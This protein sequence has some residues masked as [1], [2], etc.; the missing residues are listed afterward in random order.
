MYTMK[1]DL[2]GKEF[3]LLLLLISFVIGFP[4][5]KSLNWL[6]PSVFAVILGM[7]VSAVGGKSVSFATEMFLYLGLPPILFHSAL[8]FKLGSLKKTWLSS[9]LLSWFVTL[10]SILLIAWGILVWT[11]GTVN[12]V[13]PVEAL[14]FASVLAPTDTVAI[15]SLIKQLSSDDIPEDSRL[16]LL[17]LEN[18]S[19]MNDAICIVLVRL[20]SN[21]LESHQQLD[22]WVPMEVVGLTI[23][24]SVM[25][26]VLGLVGAVG[27][28]RANTDDMTVHYVV[29]LMIYALCECLQISGILGIF[30][31]GSMLRCPESVSKSVGSIALIIESSVYLLLGLSLHTFDTSSVGLSL[32]VLISCISARVGVVFFIGGCLRCCGR[33]YW[34]VRGLL[35]FSMCGVRGAIS[36]ALSRNLTQPFARESTYIII[37]ITMLVMGSL[38]KCMFSLLLSETTTAATLV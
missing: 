2:I 17:V 35:F 20:W 25:A 29:A 8:K 37:I 4:R 33:K 1:H 36:F 12:S 38:Q 16:V 10:L 11:R 26:V 15:L 14:L 13:S 9:I 21:M 6:P 19:V 31:Y 34:S 27:M 22:R 3:V 7:A 18:E 24:Y 28:N 5:I 32:L 23:I 30:V